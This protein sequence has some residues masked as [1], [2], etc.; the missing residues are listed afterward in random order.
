MFLTQEDSCKLFWS[1]F[2][3][4]RF[5][6]MEVGTLRIS[7]ISTLLIKFVLNSID[8]IL[9]VISGKKLKII[10]PYLFEFGQWV[11]I[12][13]Y[14]QWDVLIMVTF[15]SLEH[16]CLSEYSFFEVYAQ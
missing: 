6:S 15:Q 12:L 4:H 3:K 1:Y 2:V 5:C 11:H 16:L 8:K 9:Y 10:N 13:F 14:S 7:L